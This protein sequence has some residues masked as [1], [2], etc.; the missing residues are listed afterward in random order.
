MIDSSTTIRFELEI[1]A[2]KLINQYLLDNESIKDGIQKGIEHVFE[3]F[4]FI[5]AVKITITE[6]FDNHIK[7]EAITE[8]IAKAIHKQIIRPIKIAGKK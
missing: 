6:A 3:K 8:E 1:H 5:E 2:K 4:N 7:A